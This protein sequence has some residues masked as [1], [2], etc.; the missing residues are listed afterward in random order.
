M[1]RASVIVAAPSC[2]LGVVCP[3]RYDAIFGDTLGSVEPGGRGVA[4]L[5]KRDRLEL[6]RAPLRAGPLRQPIGAE[7]PRFPRP[8]ARRAEEF[9]AVRAPGLEVGTLEQREQRWH[10]GDDAVGGI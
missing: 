8:V 1:Y 10:R 2:L 5:L 3:I 9:T 7:Q 4:A 6:G